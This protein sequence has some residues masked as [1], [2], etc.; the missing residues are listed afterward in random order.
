MNKGVIITLVALFVLTAC[1]NGQTTN[2]QAAAPAPIAPAEDMPAPAAP[3]ENNVSLFERDTSATV[4]GSAVKTTGVNGYLARPKLAGSYPGVVMIHEWWGLNDN[5]RTMARLL[6]SEGYIVYAVDLYD[7]RIA[8][9]ADEARAYSGAVNAAPTAATAKLKAAVAYLKDAQK[10]P[11]IA[12]L[13]WCF[14]GAQSLALALAEPLDATVIYYGTLATS[15]AELAPLAGPVLGIFG[16]QDTSIPTSSVAA[17]QSALN[18]LGK[19]NEITVYPG[20]GHA[21]ANPTGANYAPTETI[22]AW[23]KTLAFLKRKLVNSSVATPAK[24]AATVIKLTAKNYRFFLDGRESPILRV[25]A[26]DQIRVDLTVEDGLHDFLIDGLGVATEQVDAGQTASVSFTAPAAGEY[27][28]YC[29][30]GNHRAM[31]MT[32]RLIVE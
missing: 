14:G 12:S 2:D 13:G 22:D 19:A 18:I 30:V 6:A 5:I 3:A 16:D 7:G 15:T 32:G 23:Q 20:V 4:D 21:F 1:F 8:T 27:E 11:K 29:S 24:E 10:V 25:K 31:G 17:F 28:Y 26:G 9:T